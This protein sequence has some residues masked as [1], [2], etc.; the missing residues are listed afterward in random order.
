MN[1]VTIQLPSF[2]INFFTSTEILS[3]DLTKY[4]MDK[5]TTL[6]ASLLYP[7]SK[8]AEIVGTPAHANRGSQVG[9]DG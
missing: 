2:P 1:T 4:N 9:R 5:R 3:I 7:C 8:D 6:L